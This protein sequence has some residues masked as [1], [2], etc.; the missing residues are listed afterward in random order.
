LE[1]DDALEAL[2]VVAVE[3]ALVVVVDVVDAAAV[4][5]PLREPP[6]RLEDGICWTSLTMVE[7]QLP[8][9]SLR[10]K[11]PEKARIGFAGLLG[12]GWLH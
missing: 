5:T 8:V 12:S 1:V 3:P 6:D 7:F 11:K 4:S 9:M 2:V 10:E